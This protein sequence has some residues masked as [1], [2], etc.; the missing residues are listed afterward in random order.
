MEGKIRVGAAEA[1]DEVIFKGADGSF[2]GIST[3]NAWWNK[4]WLNGIGG[5]EIEQDVGTFVVKAL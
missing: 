1:G 2:S 3:V 4:L 5:H